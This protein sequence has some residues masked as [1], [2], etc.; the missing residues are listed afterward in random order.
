MELIIQLEFTQG[1]QLLQQLFRF[2]AS[3]ITR[4]IRRVREYIIIVCS[5]C[6]CKRL[7]YGEKVEEI[8]GKFQSS[9]LCR[10]CFDEE[11]DLEELNEEDTL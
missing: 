10:Q 3:I 11:I 7:I 8:N 2:G 4:M 5:R 9:L 6:Q 1:Q